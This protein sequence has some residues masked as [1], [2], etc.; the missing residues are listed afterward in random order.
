MLRKKLIVGLSLPHLVEPQT[1]LVLQ[2]GTFLLPSRIYYFKVIKLGLFLSYRIRMWWTAGGGA[3]VA[4]YL[5]NQGHKNAKAAAPQE[6]QEH[7][8]ANQEYAKRAEGN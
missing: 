3:V 8:G 5:W 1:V 2:D 7:H 6:F 4:F